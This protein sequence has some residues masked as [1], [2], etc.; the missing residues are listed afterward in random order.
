MIVR[1]DF[2]NSAINWLR[3]KRMPALV[4]KE[5]EVEIPAEGIWKFNVLGIGGQKIGGDP[6]LDCGSA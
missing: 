4:S 2:I 3:E 6:L 1:M 5:K